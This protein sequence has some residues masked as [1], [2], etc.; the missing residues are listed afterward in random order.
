MGN[1]FTPEQKDYVNETLD[2]ITG[3]LEANFQGKLTADVN[4]YSNA[5]WLRV[6]HSQISSFSSL[7]SLNYF[8]FFRLATGISEQGDVFNCSSTFR[9]PEALWD[10]IGKNGRKTYDEHTKEL[11][12][13][14]RD[15]GKIEDLEHSLSEFERDV[16]I[17]L[18]ELVTASV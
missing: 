2:R 13:T 15:I 16:R 12:I 11:K 5:A 3:K 8:A 10:I 4:T 1:S 9:I 14:Y 18:N 6:Y 7:P 17:I